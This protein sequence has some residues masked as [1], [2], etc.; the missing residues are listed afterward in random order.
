[1]LSR[2]AAEPE[3]STTEKPGYRSTAAIKLAYYPEWDFLIGRDR[4]EWTTVVEYE[5]AE[6][7]ADKIEEILEGCPVGLRR[8]ALAPV[9]QVEHAKRATPD[10][11]GDVDSTN[12]WLRPCA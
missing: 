4:N 2:A 10:V 5:P 1:M 3:N 12:R 6:G 11:T 8:V 9:R 7:H